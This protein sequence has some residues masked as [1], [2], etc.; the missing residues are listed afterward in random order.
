VAEHW[1]IGSISKIGPVGD[2]HV[3][4]NVEVQ[5]RAKALHQ[6]HLASGTRKARKPGLGHLM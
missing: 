4:V 5:R 3:K 2:E 6:R 1:R